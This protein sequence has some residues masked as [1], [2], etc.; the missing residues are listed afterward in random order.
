MT[1]GSRRDKRTPDQEGV[2]YKT[3]LL[4][5]KRGGNTKQITVDRGFAVKINISIANK[6][7]KG[8]MVASEQPLIEAAVT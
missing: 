6:R 8:K 4:S 5:S 1:R 3:F 7:H 2:Q